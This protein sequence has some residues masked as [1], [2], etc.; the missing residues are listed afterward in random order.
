L[1]VTGGKLTT[2]RLIAQDALESLR[3]HFPDLPEP[4]E[5]QP[6][7]DQ[8]STD[9]PEQ[10]GPQVQRRLLGRYGADVSDLLETAQPGELTAIVDT[11]YLWAEL[12]WAARAE[13]VV[14]LDDLLLRRVRLG[15]LLPEGGADYLDRIRVICQPELSWNDARWEAEVAAYRELW[16]RCYSLPANVPDWRVMLAEKE[17][18]EETAV[19]TSPRSGIVSPQSPTKPIRLAGIL[20]FL[21]LILALLWWHSRKTE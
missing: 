2:F 17:R 9:L 6:V 3:D 19:S 8:V 1:T 12:R 13:G 10:L 11:P 7:L 4:D 21:A 18:K 20:T 5:K 16:Q 15:L 14:H